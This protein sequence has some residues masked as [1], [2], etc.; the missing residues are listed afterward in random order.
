MSNSPVRRP[1]LR[2]CS[3]EKGN[4]FHLL[5]LFLSDAVK[6]WKVRI[7]KDL[8]AGP[9]EVGDS[10]HCDSA[11]SGL[12]SS[13][14][15]DNVWKGSFSSF[16]YQM[17]FLQAMAATSW[18]EWL[19]TP[20]SFVAEKEADCDIGPLQNW[21]GSDTFYATAQ[22]ILFPKEVLWKQEEKVLS[23]RPAWIVNWAT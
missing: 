16:E 11:P 10:P 17:C 5:L 13:C 20:R 21:S 23:F 7:E 14:I 2:G 18:G 1:S 22:N 6:G 19:G 8:I 15:K 4:V 9:F 3:S 12:I